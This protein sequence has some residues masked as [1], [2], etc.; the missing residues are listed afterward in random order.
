MHAAGRRVQIVSEK[1]NIGAKTMLSARSSSPGCARLS[2]DKRGR[3]SGTGLRAQLRY[4]IDMHDA[5]TN[6]SGEIG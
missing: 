1:T 4:L 2:V 6:R 5:R 3:R